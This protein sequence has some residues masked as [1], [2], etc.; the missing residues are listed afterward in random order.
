MNAEKRIVKNTVFLTAG[1][2]LGDLLTF[3]FLV[4]FARYFGVD[5]MGKYGFAMALGGLLS[6]GVTL[7]METLLV[8]EVSQDK[9]KY[10]V[11][12]GNFLVAQTVLALLI[13]SLI[14]LIAFLSHWSGD[15]KLIIILLGAYHVLFKLSGLFEA[16]F[17][18]HEEMH[19]SAFLETSHKIVILILG[20]GAIFLWRNPMA[21]LAAYPVSGLARCVI[22][23]VLSGS[24]YG[25]P[26]LAVDYAFLKKAV[27][28]SIPFLVIILL[29]QFYD[30]LGIILLT[31]MRGE[32]QSGVYMAPERLVVT[33]GVALSMFGTALLPSMS[34]LSHESDRDFYKLYERATRLMVIATVPAATLLFVLSG[35]I[36][37]G[38][39]GN[40][41]GESIA[42]LQILSWGLVLAGIRTVM[43][44]LI[45]AKHRERA[46][47]GMQL[48]VYLAYALAC[49][50][51]I[52]FFGYTGLA[53]VKLITQA[54]LVATAY[55]YI[56]K[57]FHRSDLVKLATG[58]LLSC[59]VAGG[60]FYLLADRSLW[61]AVP[62][63]LA[64]LVFSMFLF[65]AVQLND[66]VF[67]KTILMTRDRAG[68]EDEIEPLVIEK[69]VP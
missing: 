22:G 26:P 3:L 45:I 30:R 18:A 10:L 32:S 65:K 21:A 35:P 48:G 67:L 68:E 52:P 38:L 54:L 66:L 60:S 36:M 34:R 61:L 24:R 46:W 43:N 8:R 51:M 42:V 28:R 53:Y 49:L 25:W 1:K 16:E 56:R 11:Y 69:S 33:L 12:A 9:S 47:V 7:G 44:G 39:F 55:V 41:F 37:I 40:A 17:R 62:A 20:M 27:P 64:V 50:I 5:F 63:M 58:P 6:V 23:F 19:F 31:L 4:Y 57:Y 13:W 15:T 59:A 14:A 2:A 29:G